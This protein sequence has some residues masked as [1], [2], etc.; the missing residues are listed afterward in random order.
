MGKNE[1]KNNILICHFFVKLAFLF[2]H[3][4]LTIIIIIIIIIIL[5]IS[6][7]FTRALADDFSLGFKWQ[8]VSLSIQ[9][10]SEYSRQFQQ[11]CSLDGLH[12]SAYLQVFKSRYQSFGDCTERADY[13]WYHRHSHVS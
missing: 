8:Q 2:H 9:D 3:F 10:S 6:E 5:L 11:C 13:N 7:F 12:S 1:K 4:V